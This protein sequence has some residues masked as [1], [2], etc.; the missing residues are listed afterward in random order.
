MRIGEPMT[1][2]RVPRSLRDR[3]AARAATAGVTMAEAIAQA[4]E[5]GDEAEFWSGVGAMPAEAVQSDGALFDAS[6]RDGLAPQPL[7]R[8]RVM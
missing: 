2:I 3:V 5:Q 4:L 7:G 1:T 6:L 8:A